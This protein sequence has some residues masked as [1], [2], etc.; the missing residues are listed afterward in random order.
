MR[1]SNGIYF[2]RLSEATPLPVIRPEGIEWVEAE[3]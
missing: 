2:G 3:P 1:D